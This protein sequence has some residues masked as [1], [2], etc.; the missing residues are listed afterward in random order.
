MLVPVYLEE[1]YERLSAS[2]VQSA[3][4]GH[5]IETV[6]VNGNGVG[7]CNVCDGHPGQIYRI[8]PKNDLNGN[9]SESASVNASTSK[10]RISV[11]LCPWKS[12]IGPIMRE[13]LDEPLPTQQPRPDPRLKL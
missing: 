11:S 3:R 13:V 12:E 4:S 9:E 7:G 6:N 5:G 1:T 8:D 2:R 10:K